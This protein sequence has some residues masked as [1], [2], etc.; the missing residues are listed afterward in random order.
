MFGNKYYVNILFSSPANLKRTPL[1][2]QM[3][4]L[5]VHA[6]QVGNPCSMPWVGK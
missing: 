1:D 3:Y 4:P 2:R 5:G 6:P